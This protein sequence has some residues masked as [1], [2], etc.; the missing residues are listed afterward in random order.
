MDNS[1]KV[2]KESKQKIVEKMHGSMD[3]SSMPQCTI[4]G[5]KVNNGPEC[6][7]PKVGITSNQYPPTLSLDAA[8]NKSY[9][10]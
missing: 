4:E 3:H 10:C 1:K 6:L 5:K 9:I 7:C 2:V 8:G